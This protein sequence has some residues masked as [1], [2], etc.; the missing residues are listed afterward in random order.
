MENHRHGLDQNHETV[1]VIVASKRQLFDL[2]GDTGTLIPIQLASLEPC[3]VPVR[4]RDCSACDIRL[5]PHTIKLEL[6]LVIF[7]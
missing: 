4:L 3:T 7:L 5:R 6:N 1:C 2:P